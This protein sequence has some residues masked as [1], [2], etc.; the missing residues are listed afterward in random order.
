MMPSTDPPKPGGS[1]GGAIYQQENEADTVTKRALAPFKDLIAGTVAGML[2]K[3][4]EFPLDT[5]KVIQQTGSGN[6]GII[7]TVS[8][9]VKERGALG[10]YQGLA[11]PL[12]G[13]MAENAVL[14]FSYGIAKSLLKGE[15]EDELPLKKVALAGSFSGVAV[16]TVLTPVE[17]L[18]CR[19]QVMAAKG[20]EL[21][22]GRCLRDTYSE[23][24]LRSLYKGYVSTLLR[25]IPG[26]AAWFGVYE[27]ACRYQMGDRPRESLHGGNLMFAGGLAGVAYWSAF[28]PADV[29][30]SRI[31]TT[32]GNSKFWD[33]FAAIYR[34]KGLKGLYSGYPVTV[35]RAFPSNAVVFAT[36]EF[37]MRLID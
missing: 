23:G 16:S 37:I 11:S 25:E 14:F 28:F 30:K 4:V 15:E 9:I 29:V 24:G 36:Y 27:L 13:A 12:V 33:V 1:V 6:V 2:S 3:V 26:N 5:V 21:S 34:E 17:L 32:A 19:M 22:F 35:L 8:N 10:L 7:G 18:K 31:Q 20:Y